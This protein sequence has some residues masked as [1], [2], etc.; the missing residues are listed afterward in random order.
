MRPSQPC[1][2]FSK[3]IAYIIVNIGNT[4]LMQN[5][6]QQSGDKGGVHKKM[7]NHL[8]LLP[9]GG[10]LRR[11]LYVPFPMKWTP[12]T[13]LFVYFFTKHFIT[14]AKEFVRETKTTIFNS[15]ICSQIRAK[16][17]SE[18]N[19]AIK[20]LQKYSACWQFR[21]KFIIFIFGL[22]G[23]WHVAFNLQ[24]RRKRRACVQ[25]FLTLTVAF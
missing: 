20:V 25:C 21:G 13:V 15:N 22:S 2:G 7:R 4:Q 6:R 18:G 9:F 24:A 17:S 10:V 23:P 14:N 11:A 16:I 8:R 19:W 1:T 5:N 3:N 12:S